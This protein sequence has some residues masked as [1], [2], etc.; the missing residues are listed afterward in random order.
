MKPAAFL[1]PRPRAIALAALLVLLAAPRPGAA[2][3]GLAEHGDHD[4]AV[5]TPASVLGYELGD[6]LTPHHMV[7]RYLTRLAESS[8]RI[9]VDTVGYSH[10]GRPVLLAIA[11]SAANQARL[12]DI[13]AVNRRIADPRGGPAAELDALAETA[14]VVVWLGY[15]VHG[16]EASGTEAALGTLYQL[17]AGQDPGTL[18]V[19]E[20]VV[21]LIDPVQNPDGHDRHV[22]QVAWDL[23][24]FGPDPFPD[25]VVHG[26]DWH[27]AR[28]NHYL[29]D[30]NRD[31]I[32]H[33]HPE[34][35]A[36]MSVF[37]DWFPHVAADLH[38]MGSNSTYFFAPPMV[39]IHANIHPLVRKGWDIWSRGNAAAF[40]EHGWGFFTREGYDEFYPGYGPSWP[41]HT[42]A[43]GM[44]YEQGSSEGGA[45]RRDDGTVLTLREATRHH[46]TASR[47]TL[48]TAATH[49]AERVADYLAFRR[50]AVEEADDYAIRT[51]LV[52]PDGQARADSLVAVLLR[53]GIEVERLADDQS[54]D[55]TDY[56][57][58]SARRITFPSGTYVIDVA[59]PQGMLARTLLEPDPTFDPVFIRE[60]LERRE[61]GL[62]D[63]FYDMT[64]WSLPFLFRVDAAWAGSTVAGV[65]PVRELT[66]PAP[67]LPREARYAYAF[68]PGSE[69]SLRLLGR[70]L[71]E[72]VRVRH[73][74]RP[75]TID[76]H[77]FPDGAFL[78]LV[79]RNRGDDDG[80]SLHATVRRLAGSAG[81]RV[82]PLDHALADTGTDLGSNRVAAIPEP[83]VALAAGDGVSSYSYGAAW[84]VFDQRLRF[85]VT[86]IELDDLARSLDEFNVVVIPSAYRLDSSLGES[87][88]AALRRWVE[89]G[90][91][92]ITLDGATAWLASDHGLARLREGDEEPDSV[93]GTPLPVSIP[94]A[95]AR[96]VAD[97]LSP[98]LAGVRGT[99]VPV[100]LDG[101]RFYRAPED[102][103]PGEVVLRYADE[104]RL[105]L[106][107]YLWPEAPARAA[108]GVFL[109]TERS[110]SGRVIA[111]THD[112]NA[113]A[114][115]RGLLPVFANAV[116]LGGSY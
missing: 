100:M 65:E 95:I 8:P 109:W 30:L 81:V 15:T 20:N 66:S 92:L 16:D 102:V 84:F 106:A 1:S 49:R 113:R 4:P 55:A 43:V 41:I 105:R 23:G 22:H 115:W 83:K 76:G 48:R 110:G 54:V 75:F 19:L 88:T 101:S 112:P 59:Q 97:T 44:T 38:E 33:A 90:G 79:H 11:T 56:G 7:I 14:P 27:G 74:T 85:P 10:E 78:V 6:R 114:M 21:T 32:V 69:A 52:R 68:A 26:H 45:I 36:R 46:Y 12:D 91:T 94:G 70:L 93:D 9:R 53:H 67:T 39:P 107:G 62:R 99:E 18:E 77:A 31:W 37:L 35:R 73:A 60:E 2:Q 71:G 17:A 58:E 104:G 96:A 3:H 25:A 86:R 116:F 61:A 28:S 111:F 82:T 34:T 13:R 87:G 29:F 64:G 72:G 42:G 103:E 40:A 24:A 57:E 5:P 50:A 63:R 98:L 108:G 47:A 51:I 89:Q 80:A